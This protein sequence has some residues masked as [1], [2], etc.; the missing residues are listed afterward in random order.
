MSADVNAREGWNE[1]PGRQEG[2]GSVVV[3]ADAVYTFMECTCLE[4]FSFF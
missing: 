4:C 3:H 1:L 2:K